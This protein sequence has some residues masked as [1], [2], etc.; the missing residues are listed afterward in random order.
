[1]ASAG[2]NAR[3]AR[4][5]LPRVRSIGYAAEKSSISMRQA[6]MNDWNAG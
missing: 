6:V 5:D 3:Q 1:M 4:F 2:V